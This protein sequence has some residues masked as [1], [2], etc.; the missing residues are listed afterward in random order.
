MW[1]DWAVWESGDANFSN[2]L[3]WSPQAGAYH[4]FWYGNDVTQG[5]TGMGTDLTDMVWTYRSATGVSVMTAPYTKD[6]KTVQARRLR[7]YPSDMID[8]WIVGCGR[9]AHMVVPGKVMIVRLSDGYSWLLTTSSCVGMNMATAYCFGK[10][11]A[12]SCDELFVRG[13]IGVSANVARVSF[14]ALGAGSPP[15]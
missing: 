5:A 6:P 12:L 3:A 4:Y 1:G 2:Q 10:P 9:A 11:Y 7:S 15:D 8:K 14:A 13:G